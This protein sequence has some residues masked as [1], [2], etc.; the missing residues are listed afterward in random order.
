MAKEPAI[1]TLAV[2][3]IFLLL[4]LQL[5]AQQELPPL[6]DGEGY[7]VVGIDMYNIFWTGFSIDGDGKLGNAHQFTTKEEAHL[8]DHKITSRPISLEPNQA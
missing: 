2:I 8:R 7:L 1:R 4:P 3:L 6:E 5:Q